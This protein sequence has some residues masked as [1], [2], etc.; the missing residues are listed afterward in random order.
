MHPRNPRRLTEN[1][2]RHLIKVDS[3]MSWKDFAIEH[4]LIKACTV[5]PMTIPYTPFLA[6]STCSSGHCPGWLQPQQALETLVYGEDL[7]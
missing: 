3:S 1:R 4:N 6:I 2:E 7:S 5:I